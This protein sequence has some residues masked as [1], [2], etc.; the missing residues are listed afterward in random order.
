[1][2]IKAKSQSGFLQ[3]KRILAREKANLALLLG[4]GI[5]LTSGASGGISWDQL[6]EN[7]IASA[8]ANSPRPSET[9]ARLK[10]L[11]ERGDNG[12]TAA[13]LPE[14]FDIIEATGTIQ[15]VAT[16]QPS[17]QLDLQSRIA[18]MLKGMKPGAPHKAV[19][20]WA[21]Q[22]QVPILTTNYDHCFQDALDRKACKKQRFG[23]GKPHSDYYPWDRYYAPNKI[24]DPANAFAVWH[25][26]GDQDLKR[27]IRAGLDQ[28]MGMVERLR[29][30]KRSV[31]KEILRGPN[32]DGLRD[33]AFHAAPWLRTFMGKKLWIQGLGLRAAEVSIRWLLVQRFRYWRRYKPAHRLES[34]WYVHGPTD[35][36]GQLEK[37][38]RIFFESVGL[39]V[40]EIATPDEAYV[41]LLLRHPNKAGCLQ[42]QAERL[43]MD[44][45]E[46]TD[47]I[48]CA[49]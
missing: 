20:R 29:K 11:L 45:C 30:L 33:P 24:A 25:I 17:D 2:K 19:A 43:R 13:S 18:Q 16:K 39:K 42:I 15:A 47:G 5:N 41:D 35:G 4:N 28:Y 6:M 26:H 37:E 38:R 12:V 40:I 49:T 14:V 48:R 31:A 21:I 46:R 22:S 23:N 32:E 10:R 9:T 27:S 44:P 7:L 3:A 8:A 36:T 1:M 34:G